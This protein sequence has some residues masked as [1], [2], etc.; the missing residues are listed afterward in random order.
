MLLLY[1]CKNICHKILHVCKSLKINNIM[2]EED[3]TTKATNQAKQ[4]EQEG[5]MT[6]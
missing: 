1:S 6:L 5:K 2:I 4:R 3:K